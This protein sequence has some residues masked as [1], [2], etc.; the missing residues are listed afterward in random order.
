MIMELVE[1]VDLLPERFS[2]GLLDVHSMP[3]NLEGL[4]SNC[5][6]EYYKHKKHFSKMLKDVGMLVPKM[7][8]TRLQ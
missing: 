8:E 6:E 7:K 5:Y 1:S 3:I 2:A 4:C